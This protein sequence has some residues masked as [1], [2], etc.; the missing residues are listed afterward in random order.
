[1]RRSLHMFAGAG[2]RKPEG[3][4]ACGELLGLGFDEMDTKQ[5]A[6]EHDVELPEVSE[7]VIDKAE[8]GVWGYGHFGPP[9]RTYSPMLTLSG[10]QKRSRTE[11]WG[12]EG[13]SDVHQAVVDASNTHLDVVCACA[14][15]ILDSGGEISIE[16]VADYGD[17]D[18]P[19][20][21]PARAS[22]CPI[23]LTPQMVALIAEYGLRQVHVPLCAFNNGGPRKWLTMWVSM[24]AFEVLHPLNDLRCTHLPHEHGPSIGRAADGTP[25]SELT[26]CYPLG[27]NEWLVRVPDR[28]CRRPAGSAGREIAWGAEL[29]PAVRAAVEAQ[30]RSPA[31]FASPRKRVAVPQEARWREAI[32]M[33]HEVIPEVSGHRPGTDWAVLEEGPDDERPSTWAASA[34]R[35]A[36]PRHAI[37]G[38]PPGKI[39]YE[40][41]WRSVPEQGGRRVGY[42][43]IMGWLARATTAAECM[44][45]GRPYESPGT[46]VIDN[47]LKEPWARPWLLDTR[48]P[49]DVVVAR[50]STRHTMFAGPRQVSRESIRDTADATGWRDIDPD[51]VDQ[52]G[53]GGW[54]SSSFCGRH[55]VFQ[56]HSIGAS[57]HYADANAIA[58]A[59]YRDEWKI[60]PF[61]TPP[62]EPARTIPQ[63]VVMQAR[64]KLDPTEPDGVR[65]YNKP[66]TTTNLSGGADDVNSGVLR[67]DRAVNMPSAQTHA[68]GCGVVQAIGTTARVPSGQFGID[69]SSAYC[70]FLM[71]RAEWWMQLTFWCISFPDGSS[72]TGWFINP[73]LVFGGAFGPNRFGRFSRMKRARG[74]QRQRQFDEECPLPAK[75]QTVLRERATLQGAGGA[76]ARRRRPA[77][78][79]IAAG[80]H[81]R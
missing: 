9:C 38:A 65:R 34:T 75:V 49:S 80:L 50:R 74:F 30:R 12:V 10:T 19:C 79:S 29:H 69:L 28:F 57:N 54:E 1:M 78:C 11:P 53:E 37:P 7:P 33:P 31:G 67:N 32:P 2:P 17:P 61:L 22:M 68:A 41:I 43:L 59:E 16:S 15:G 60:G 39:T 55:S 62:F 6:V 76:A 14:R 40:M 63:N 13:L 25:N 46:L 81:R 27:L 36:R 5:D 71:Q 72:L 8:A 45:D 66:R 35:P 26:A 24:G 70:F 51:M 23:G 18:G 47:D 3:L 42:E 20:W 48:D 52:A 73:R 56:W 21:W 58:V 44:A 64:T 77:R 4:A